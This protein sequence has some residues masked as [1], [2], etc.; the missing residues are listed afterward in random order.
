MSDEKTILSQ[1]EWENSDTLS[2]LEWHQR[3]RAFGQRAQRL[4]EELKQQ[5]EANYQQAAARIQPTTW[6]QQA[7]I[8]KRNIEARKAQQALYLEELR[9][10]EEEKRRKAANEA[11]I[12]EQIAAFEAKLRAKPR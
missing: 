10:Q 1:Q 2:P 9:K 4:Q 8:A 11:S 7:E 3:A 5:A 6:Q 12:A